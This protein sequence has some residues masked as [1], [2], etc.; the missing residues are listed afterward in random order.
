LFRV[1]NTTFK[2]K[3]MNLIRWEPFTGVDDVFGRM[4]GLLARWPRISIP[5]NGAAKFE[6]SPSADIS[7]TEKEYLI[8]AE[9][10]A[11]RK[12]D[13]K[14]TVDK[15]S[16]TI[17]GERRQN[18][19][20]KTEKIHRTESFR[21]TFMRSFSLPEDANSEAV[22]CESKDGILTVHIPKVEKQASQAKRIPVG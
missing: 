17:E 10:P 1:R 13:V 3:H 21:G 16:I 15:G 11:V 18:T 4:P 8:R 9:I 2:E 20:E 6:W 12:E 5:E 7:E 14:V 22:R 19:Q